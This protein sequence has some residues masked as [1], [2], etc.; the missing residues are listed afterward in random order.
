[1]SLLSLLLVLLCAL[2]YTNASRSPPPVVAIVSHP[3]NAT[4]EYIATSYIKNL[5]MSGARVLRVPYEGADDL[6]WVKENTNA[7]FLMGGSAELTDGVR[8]L[9]DAVRDIDKVRTGR[10]DRKTGHRG[11]ISNTSVVPFLHLLPPSLF[12][13]QSGAPVLVSSGSIR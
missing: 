8:E 11:H 6:E 2:A 13:T 10:E 7:L 12:S 9:F 1:M 4:H 5:E 3:Y